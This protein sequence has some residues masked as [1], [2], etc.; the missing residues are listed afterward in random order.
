L[1]IWL[2]PLNMNINFM[3]IHIMKSFKQIIKHCKKI[4]EVKAINLIIKIFL[5]ILLFIIKL[6]L[7]L[8]KFDLSLTKEIEMYRNIPPIDT[9]K[10]LS[11]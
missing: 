8:I 1:G 3:M 10:K 2:A 5:I 7:H 11:Q 4:K 6:S 9:K